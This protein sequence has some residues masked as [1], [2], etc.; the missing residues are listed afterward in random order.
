M[1]EPSRTGG[2]PEAAPVLSL[3]FFSP[4]FLSF[5][6]FFFLSVLFHY[7]FRLFFFV[8]FLRSFVLS[9]F[10]FI[11]WFFLVSSCPPKA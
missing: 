4:L 11:L 1:L 5:L 8:L 6:C 10:S 9:F 7:V 3:V 2:R